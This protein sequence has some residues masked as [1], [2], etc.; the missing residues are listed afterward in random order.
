MKWE[1]ISR[2]CQEMQVAENV[3]TMEENGKLVSNGLHIKKNSI[4]YSSSYKSNFGDILFNIFV[5]KDLTLI[6]IS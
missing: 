3:K 2:L 1:F 5:C 6:V 4:F